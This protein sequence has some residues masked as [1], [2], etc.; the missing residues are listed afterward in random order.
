MTYGAN[1][2]VKTTYDSTATL[3]AGTAADVVALTGNS[4]LA[5]PASAFALNTEGKTVTVGANTLTLG[6]GVN[7]AGLILAT[8][9]QINGGTLAFG[10]SE[11]VIWMSGTN[12][13]IS[14]AITGSNGLTF[15]GSGGV[16]LSTAANV[17]G[18]VT[19]DSGAV[20]LSAA[21]V[22]SSDVSGVFLTN[23]KSHP[24]ASTLNIAASNTFSTLSSVGN[25]STITITGGSILTIGD[26]NNLSSTISSNIT[27]TTVTAGAITKNGTGL[28]D[29]SGATI[30]LAAGSSIAAN[31]GALRVATGALKNTAVVGTAPNFVLAGGADLQFAQNGGGQYAGAI[32]GAGT[33]HLIG[34]TLQLVGTAN[35]YTGGTIVE[36]GSTLDIT[37]ANLPA[38]NPNITDAGGLIVFDQATTGTY[39]GVISDGKEMGVGPMLSGSL[40]KDDSS[41][42]NTGN[43]ILTTAQTYT[44]ATTVEAGT[45]TL[46]AVD[47]LATSSGVDLGR[48]GGGSTAILALGANNTLQALTSEAGDTTTVTLGADTLTINTPTGTNAN[49]GGVISGTGAVIKTGAG[50]EVF[51]GADVYSG[52]TTVQNGVLSLTGSLNS[53]GSTTVTGGTL[54]IATTGSLV[55]SATTVGGGALDLSGSLNSGVVTVNGG[56]L[57]VANHGS[58]VTATTNVNGGVFELDSG[59]SFSSTTAVNVAAGGT[60]FAPG[61]AAAS[62][63]PAF[64]NAGVLNIRNGAGTNV[65]TV[66]AYTGVAGSQL[67]VGANFTS[68]T[69]DDLIVAGAAG[70]STIVVTDL[71][72]AT[73]LAYNPTGI[74]VVTSTGA[75]SASAFIL[76]TGPVEK[77]LFQYDLAY[78]PDPHFLLV[79]VPAAGA[80]RLSTL[81]TAAQSIWQDTAGVWLDRQ[82][83]ERDLFAPGAG[84]APAGTMTGVWARA[85][86]DW[87]DRTQ[88]Q[89]YSLLN[90]TYNYQTGY[91]QRTDGIYAGYDGGLRGPAGQDDLVLFGGEIGYIDSTQKF[92]VS[93]AA[94]D[95]QG[96]SAGLSATYLNQN[97]FVDA[98]FKADFLELSYTDPSIAG[99]GASQ[100]SGNIASYGGIIDAGYRINFAGTAFVEP[101][102]TV[103][104]VSARLDGLALAGSQ[105][106]FSDQSTVRGRLGVRGGF[107]VV[108]NSDYRVDASATGSYWARLSGGSAATINSGAAAPL[109]TLTDTQVK[110][111]G[112][113][114]IGFNV[115]SKTSGLSAFLK[116]D[117]QF[118]SSYDA[119]SVKGGV[120]YDF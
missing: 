113:A 42:G 97:F 49:F 37:T 9:S 38:T 56:T 102:A 44:G 95:Y 43:L 105:V 110:Q 11:A 13:T 100:Q 34:G 67:Q 4:T 57:D 20:T 52:G 103:A 116:G 96:W 109:L 72:P 68:K 32:S 78:S 35:T 98:L 91:N 41:G 76:A 17:S 62:V 88:T 51:S 14:S 69:A 25:N 2:Y 111:Y 89:T 59:G 71:T 58:L 77:G 80:F 84:P 114:G 86:G 21:N 8:G 70:T 40:D 99:F 16:T 30:T 90:K 85:V 119:G 108:D 46:N 65:F 87:T 50:T 28:L 5:G 22:F 53:T 23:V 29:L 33:L 18:Q 54:S 81:P 83:D 117:Y 112:E 104:D 75:M 6:D 79:S 92:K 66:G 1:G 19:I 36:I 118:G 74:P 115:F 94:A 64:N 120:R 10:S 39:A 73:P 61:G 27:D 12:P 82:N 31:A 63:T 7:P 24:A 55:T 15:T 45:L 107:T 48:V 60:F 3:N 26:G 47:T 106:T 93:S 101:Q